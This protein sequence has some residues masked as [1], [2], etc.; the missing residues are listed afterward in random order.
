METVK[1]PRDSSLLSAANKLPIEQREQTIHDRREPIIYCLPA[2]IGNASRRIGRR[3]L[4]PQGRTKSRGPWSR[5]RKC[6][7][8]T[9]TRSVSD[10]DFDAA[11]RGKSWRTKMVL[12]KPNHSRTYRVRIA[13][14]VS[15]RHAESDFRKPVKACRC[16][17]SGGVSRRRQ[18]ERRRP[19]AGIGIREW[20][21]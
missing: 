12:L 1:L 18:H 10:E 13:R 5:C 3:S 21:P 9:T 20:R 19:R 4:H 14:A 11:Q 7:Q 8:P 15:E 16:W 6:D 2:T 17:R